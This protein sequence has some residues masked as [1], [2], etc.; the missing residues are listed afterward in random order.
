[1][2]T[3]QQDADDSVAYQCP[4]E[5]RKVVDATAN[6][7]LVPLLTTVEST[8]KIKPKP[9][10]PP[11]RR[12][13]LSTILV[14]G[15]HCPPPPSMVTAAM[16]RTRPDTPITAQLSAI[17]SMIEMEKGGSEYDTII[18]GVVTANTDD[19]N[20]NADI[21]DSNTGCTLATITPYRGA[22]LWYYDF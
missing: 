12:C 10:T 5:T 17:E 2:V 11:P 16:V 3:N 1:M 6:S 15:T 19:D 20:N 21:I 9:P 4:G 18:K 7:G 22:S 8:T 13:Q 14:D